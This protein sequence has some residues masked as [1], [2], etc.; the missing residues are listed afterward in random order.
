MKTSIILDNLIIEDKREENLSATYDNNGP[1]VQPYSSGTREQ[2]QVIATKSP[3]L[4]TSHL[5][6]LYS[7]QHILELSTIIKF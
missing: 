2:L 6:V 5:F 7:D 4:K 1:L 3:C